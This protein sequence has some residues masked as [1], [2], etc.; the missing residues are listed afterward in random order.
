[1]LT[2]PTASKLKLNGYVKLFN[3]K[4]NIPLQ[5]THLLLKC[6][7]HLKCIV[8]FYLSEVSHWF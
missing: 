1:M 6:C 4:K 2:H 3:I 5:P 8:F 7:Y